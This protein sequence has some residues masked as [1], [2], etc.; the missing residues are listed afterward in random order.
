MARER[1]LFLDED[2]DKRLSRE[3]MARGRRCET[4]YRTDL[5]GSTDEALL[6]ALN[7]TYGVDVVL[8]TGN[9]GMPIENG[10]GFEVGLVAV[11]TVDT[12]HPDGYHLNEWR[13]EVIHRWAH[14]IQEQDAGTIR[15]YGAASHRP[16]TLRV[17]KRLCTPV[18]GTK[19]AETL[20]ASTTCLRRRRRRA[21][22]L[23]VRGNR[24][25]AHEGDEGWRPTSSGSGGYLPRRSD[26]TLKE[27]LAAVGARKHVQ[28]PRPLDLAGFRSGQGVGLVNAPRHCRDVPR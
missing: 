9:D 4:I 1:L 19:L 28:E 21:S 8:V 11:A 17:Q 6:T 13:R 16:W 25:A 27:A 23:A 26:A 5:Q 20:C 15:R 10:D 12:E 2:L 14:V 22:T 3:L 24:A 7:A 18:Q